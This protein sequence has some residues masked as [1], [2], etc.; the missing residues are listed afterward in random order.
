M[1]QKS[2]IGIL[3]YKKERAAI[4]ATLK[5]SLFLAK[6]KV[7]SYSCIL[8]RMNIMRPSNLIRLFFS[9]ERVCSSCVVDAV[10]FFLLSERTISPL[11]KF[12]AA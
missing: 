5:S 2:T 10:R 9:R 3:Q 7:K 8:G 1:D 6:N 11:Y 4:I 12:K